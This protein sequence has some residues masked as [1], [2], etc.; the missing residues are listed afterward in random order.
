MRVSIRGVKGGDKNTVNSG[1]YVA[2]LGVGGIAGQRATREDGRPACEYRDPVPPL[3]SRPD[4]LISG[5]PDC[6]R[7]KF[8]V[9]C[10]QLLQGDDIGLRFPKPFEQVWQAAIDVVDIEARNSR[11]AI[12]CAPNRAASN[13]RTI[14]RD[15]NFGT[16]MNSAAGPR[17]ECYAPTHCVRGRGEDRPNAARGGPTRVA[18]LCRRSCE[19]EMCRVKA[20][21]FR[22]RPRRCFDPCASR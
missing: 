8:H 20:R 21:R 9:R 22:S 5:V 16:S 14:V 15:G 18:N 19:S 2:A 3:L 12:S 13:F 6:F 7:G 4:C 10:F 17:Q 1:L 11:L